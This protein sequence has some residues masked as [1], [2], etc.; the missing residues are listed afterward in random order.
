MVLQLPRPQKKKKDR[1]VAAGDHMSKSIVT[2]KLFLNS[3]DNVHATMVL[4][5][6]SNAH[7]PQ[8]KARVT[9]R[10]HALSKSE[11]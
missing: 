8:P 2:T 4:S 9:V 11:P 10:K 6:L 5:V 1:I 3:S 7:M